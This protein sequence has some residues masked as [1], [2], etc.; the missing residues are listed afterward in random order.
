MI[1][2]N[3][4]WEL[5]P[6]PR[7]RNV[8]GVK[9]VFRTKFNPDG[10]INKH[11]ARLV[12]KGYSQIFG[13]DYLDTFAPVARHDT[14]RLLLAI[15][16]QKGW[17][18]FHM[19]IKST[20]LNGFLQEE[21]YVEQLE[22]FVIK[23]Q[24]DKVY[25]L[26]KALYGLKQAPRVWYN[27]INDHLLHLGFQ[28]CLSE[29]TLYAK[30]VGVD[31]LIIF[32][33]VGD[34]LMTRSNLTLIEEFKQEMKDVFEMTDLGL[35]TYFLGMEI[36]QKKNEIF[37]CLKK[38]AKEIFKKFQ[39]CKTMNTPMNQKEKFIKDDGADKV[40]EVHFRSLIGC[41]M[42]L[43]T[44]RPDIL[45]PVSLLSRFMH[46]ASELHLKAAKRVVRYIKGTINYGVK[47]CKV[48]DFK[49][50]GFSGSDW[51]GSLDDMKSTSGYCFNMGSSVFSWCSKKQEVVAQST[52]E[53][54]F[55]A[56]VNQA[57]WLRNVLADLGLKQDEGTKVSIDNQAAISISHNPVFHGKT[58]HFNIKLFYLREVQENGDVSLVY[59]KTE[60]QAAD[61]FT[62]SFPLSRF[63]FLRKKLG[64][65][66]LQGKEEC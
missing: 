32:L 53:A 48:Q 16:A 20:F 62:K 57:I 37:I 59:C 12:V 42:Y 58:K 29:A 40:D 4:T 8:I 3:Q 35:M 38:Y 17:Q 30:H 28:K 13:I 24:E 15:I 2:K 49:L 60:D 22:G 41:L 52:A 54:E 31:I 47:Y 26:K 27:I 34:L 23:G 39:Q 5:V 19:D 14:I 61:M 25:L 50:S 11:K 65:C 7:D 66:S 10:S 36:T 21:I 46:C 44:T 51:A 64:V 55:V 45:F 6:R 9:W 33:Y 43:T 56:A 18:V 63:E 1:E